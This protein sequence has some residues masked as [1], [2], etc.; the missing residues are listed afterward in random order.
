MDAIKVD[1]SDINFCYN[2]SKK[3]CHLLLSYFFSNLPKY[4]L[5]VYLLYYLIFTYLSTLY[6]FFAPIC[7][8]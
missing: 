5:P 4:W 1:G 3:S 8:Y 6:S 7:S 2:F